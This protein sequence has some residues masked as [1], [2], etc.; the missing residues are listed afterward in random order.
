[1]SV[2]GRGIVN[3]DVPSDSIIV[4][5]T[6]KNSSIASNIDV[7]KVKSLNSQDSS[8]DSS[9]SIASSSSIASSASSSDVGLNLNEINY[10]KDSGLLSVDN[11]GFDTISLEYETSGPHSEVVDESMN[12]LVMSV[13]SDEHYTDVEARIDIPEGTDLKDVSLYWLEENTTLNFSGVDTN[14]NGIFDAISFVIPHLSNQTFEMTLNVINV[15][16]YPVLYGLWDVEFAVT[17]NSDL[18]IY[19][20][21]TTFGKD[22]DFF[23]LKCGDV[24]VPVELIE[25]SGNISGNDSGIS[26]GFVARNYSCNSNSHFV[27]KELSTGSHH[28]KFS[29]GGLEAYAHNYASNS[30]KYISRRTVGSGSY[31]VKFLSS[32]STT[33]LSLNIFGQSSG[34]TNYTISCASPYSDNYWECVWPSHA[35]GN[36][37]LSTNATPNETVNVSLVSAQNFLTSYLQSNSGLT[38]VTGF[39]NGSLDCVMI[40]LNGVN[41]TN[42]YSPIFNDTY[43][44]V[45]LSARE[46]LSVI[47]EYNSTSGFNKTVLNINSTYI[48]PDYGVSWIEAESTSVTGCTY[49]STSCYGGGSCIKFC[50]GWSP[51]SIDFGMA[52][53]VSA[54]YLWIRSSVNESIVNKNS[55]YYLSIYDG[56]SWSSEI[57][58]TVGTSGVRDNGTIFQWNKI[59]ISNISNVS[60]LQIR[61][62]DDFSP[63][64]DFLFIDSFVF[65]NDSAYNPLTSGNYVP[66]SLSILLNGS[67]EVWQIGGFNSTKLATI[68]DYTAP[69]RMTGARVCSYVSN[70]S[71]GFNYPLNVSGTNNISVRAY[72]GDSYAD[73]N[74]YVVNGAVLDTSLVDSHSQSDYVVGP[75]ESLNVSITATILG[76]A[77]SN[78]TLVVN[79]SANTTSNGLAYNATY[80]TTFNNGVYLLS[81][82]APNVPGNYNLTYN[83]YVGSV[84]NASY[85]TILYVRNL[86]GSFSALGTVVNGTYYDVAGNI[87]DGYD[88]SLIGGLNVNSASTSAGNTIAVYYSTDGNSWNVL[89][90]SNY[91]DV[92]LKFVLNG[93]TTPYVDSF[94]TGYSIIDFNDSTQFSLSNALLR[95]GMLSLIPALYYNSSV[96]DMSSSSITV[97]VGDSFNRYFGAIAFDINVSGAGA[98]TGNVF[99]MF[100]D[101]SN[102]IN[103]TSNSSGILFTYTGSGVSSSQFCSGNGF[104]LVNYGSSLMTV[105]LNGVPCASFAYTEMSSSARGNFSIAGNFTIGK[106]ATYPSNINI[107]SVVPYSSSGTATSVYKYNVSNYS[108]AN[109]LVAYNYANNLFFRLLSANG[110]GAQNATLLISSTYGLS[111]NSTIAYTS[112]S[113]FYAPNIYN[114]FGPSSPI[115]YSTVDVDAEF[116]DNSNLGNVSLLLNSGSGYSVY[117]TQFLDGTYDYTKFFIDT[118]PY[119][120]DTVVSYYLRYYDYNGIL[121]Q[122]SVKNF[123]VQSPYRISVFTLLSSL[124]DSIDNLI[125]GIF[126]MPNDVMMQ[127]VYPNSIQLL[128]AST[129]RITFMRNDSTLMLDK[130]K[131]NL[132][133]N[134]TGIKDDMTK[135]DGGLMPDVSDNLIIYYPLDNLKDYGGAAN[136]GSSIYNLGN[137]PFN[138]VNYTPMISNCPRGNCYTFFGS[139]ITR[140]YLATSQ[141][142]DMIP[143]SSYNSIT[144]S[145]WMNV[146]NTSDYIYPTIMDNGQS[147]AQGFINIYRNGNTL[148]YQTSNGSAVIS[149]EITYFSSAGSTWIFVTFVADYNS[150][151]VKFYKNNTLIGTYNSP[152]VSMLYPNK[153]TPL[154]LG[155]YNQGALAFPLNGSL[156]DVR[157]YNRSLDFSEIQRLYYRPRSGMYTSSVF[158][159][160]QTNPLSGNLT[161]GNITVVVSNSSN[162]T[163]LIQSRFSNDNMTWSSWYPN[164]YDDNRITNDTV[165]YS[166][167]DNSS[168]LST[169][170]CVGVCNLLNYSNITYVSGI[171]NNSAVFNNNSYVSFNNSFM[172][173]NANANFTEGTIEFWINPNSSIYS[174]ATNSSNNTSITQGVLDT[175]TGIRMYYGQVPTN[176]LVGWW[177]FNNSANDSQGS[178]HGT[179]S[180]NP[181]FFD[182]LRNFQID[183]LNLNGVNSYISTFNSSNLNFGY[184]EVTISLWMRNSDPKISDIVSTKDAGAGFSGINIYSINGI[185]YC[186]LGALGLSA[187]ETS[188]NLSY[189]AWTYLTC[190]RMQNGTNYM[191]V[192]GVLVGSSVSVGSM[193]ATRNLTFG[194]D[195]NANRYFNGAL[196]DVRIYNR[197]LSYAEAQQLYYDNNLACWNGSRYNVVGTANLPLD[198]WSNVAFSYTNQSARTYLNGTLVS[199]S[200]QGCIFNQT[201]NNLTIGRSSMNS[202]TNATANGTYYYFTGAID[203]LRISNRS[204][205]RFE[206]SYWNGYNDTSMALPYNLSS[207]SPN[208]V[209]YR[210]ILRKSNAS[211]NPM[212]SNAYIT[213]T[214]NSQ[215]ESTGYA[216]SKI[217]N[218]NDYFTIGKSYFASLTNANV[219]ESHVQYRIGRNSSGNISW[220]SWIAGDPKFTSQT[221]LLETFENTST[222]IGNASSY[223]T[224]QGY[225]GYGLGIGYHN[226]GPIAENGSFNSSDLQIKGTSIYTTG[227]TNGDTVGNSNADSILKLDFNNPDYPESSGNYYDINIANVTISNGLGYFNESSSVT[228]RS[229]NVEDSQTDFA[230]YMRFNSSELRQQEL[231]SEGLGSTYSTPGMK[232]RIMPNGTIY[233]K[234][235][236][237]DDLNGPY[238]VYGYGDR[239]FISDMQHNRI[240]VRNIS[241]NFS[242]ITQFGG[243][244]L[245][246][247][248]YPQGIS[249][250][251]TYIYIADYNNNR[252]LKYRID[253]YSYVAY[254]GSVGTGN[255]NL[256]YTR[257]VYAD[258]TYIYIADTLNN[259]VVKRWASNLSYVSQY[260]S[261]G[262]GNDQLNTSYGIGG[263]G[264]YIYVADYNNN[265]IVKRWASNL[266]Y[267]SQYGTSGSGNDQLS[268]PSNVFADGTYIYV[269]DYSNNR[270]VKRLAS[271]L[272]YVAQ[273]GTTGNGNDQFINPT[274]VWGDGTYIYIADYGNNRIVKRLASDLSYVSQ[275]GHRGSEKLTISGTG[276][277]QLY[278][279]SASWS[280]GTNLWQCL[281]M[282]SL[283]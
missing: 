170:Y 276:G 172:V 248:S 205:E 277:M 145:L 77:I 24:S 236:D 203:S 152:Y 215:Y 196:S 153:N 114:Y 98:G 148:G 32:S 8:S 52:S 14:G 272:S 257:G 238:G 76:A 162:S 188:Y 163:V 234:V 35:Y 43:F 122:S 245:T 56:N 175:G 179:I 142:I 187:N 254:N 210:V 94:N 23:S 249:G 195:G 80:N 75:N 199:Q 143:N 211:A 40:S 20:I 54:N 192:N 202:T 126:T 55:S 119:P 171:V 239:L 206:L 252:I 113:D 125:Y 118:S 74:F 17:G 49:A 93:T 45:N 225:N 65:T 268:H 208:Y 214:N 180:G 140:T 223:T 109:S 185:V 59:N 160:P 34:T 135:V 271:D 31:K 264:T 253:D 147:P 136:N 37:L 151:T 131:Y 64:G 243:P 144:I 16:S 27:S 226:F 263:D 92:Y 207:S 258:G 4:G 5:V 11:S 129:T 213:Y 81:F 189:G 21:N 200:Q 101:S 133:D 128:N 177:R 36:Y 30:L 219:T 281:S 201:S 97:P 120:K 89:D 159:I 141:P 173:G 67:G 242:Y 246:A 127:I 57:N 261:L 184:S 105:S 117:K 230:V 137:A 111:F 63:G 265:R 108:A 107:S 255:D 229:T 102:W 66:R 73:K 209:Q 166:G 70:S 250:D 79:G 222:M 13:V 241:N 274:Q 85:T 169:S 33:N 104:Y 58:I 193:N 244:T 146:Q 62:L 212:I 269:A 256:N 235:Q 68:A 7:K 132:N 83:V 279:P 266:V 29:F 164:V 168:S 191:Y 240:I 231:Y 158:T 190:T 115:R 278:N 87:S 121:G 110:F 232:I 156:D 280:D 165:F 176:G 3:V 221:L 91:S 15:Q 139:N 282:Y 283:I 237:R 116:S 10:D 183:S 130:K 262:S 25:T 95:K 42:D 12:R 167:L 6:L 41:L 251:G 96:G 247:F 38:Y 178:N 220:S 270:I 181:V 71:G 99:R 228:I 260:G 103:I 22:I 224:E 182:S 174:N 51:G 39:S 78:V 47:L 123:T 1:V 218:L 154:Y 26:S 216:E 217:L 204:L 150:K 82:N 48:Y 84:V 72:Y 19:G 44:S 28:L 138:I 233:S 106:F 100:I 9:A 46:N 2:Q 86:S 227:Y 18:Y 69:F 124:L 90:S 275:Y 134:F 155:N 197:S 161:L 273:I 267:V 88:N 194:Y 61:Y 60:T 149:P 259:R 186:D 53:S 112:A 50:D 157:I 198:Q